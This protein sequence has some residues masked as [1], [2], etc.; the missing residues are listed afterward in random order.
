MNISLEEGTLEVKI[1]NFRN[2][3]PFTN[4]NQP[5]IGL[6]ERFILNWIITDQ[7]CEDAKLNM[8]TF[9][10]VDQHSSCNDDKISSN[11]QK[12]LGYRCQCKT[13][14]E[15]N[16]YLRN[17]CKGTSNSFPR[18]LIIFTDLFFLFAIIF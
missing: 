5:F 16:P 3:F 12:I 4:E 10:C 15:G 17:G 13:G 8:T 18:S 7:S 14:Y 1:K 2:Y 9:A 11:G 6:G